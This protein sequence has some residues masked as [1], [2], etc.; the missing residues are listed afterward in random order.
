[1]MYLILLSFLV[2]A[3]YT[4]AVLV[5]QGRVPYSISATFYRLEHKKWF[6]ASMAGTALLLMP[7]VLELS[8]PG[9]ECWAF[10]ACAGMLMIG[11]APNFKDKQEGTVHDIGAM[12]TLVCSQIWVGCNQPWFLLLWVAYMTYTIIYMLTNEITEDLWRD[13]MT[14]RPMFWVEVTAIA[15]VF[16]AAFTLL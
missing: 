16:L 11:C 15:S 6:S 3:S 13:F 12:M 9:T 5:K 4:L 8:R 14:T 7:A 1:M 10:L 2:I